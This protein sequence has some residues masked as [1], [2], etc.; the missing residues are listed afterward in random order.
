MV[1]LVIQFM[2]TPRSVHYAAILCILHYVKRTLFPG[3]H[4]S[5]RSSLNLHVYSDADW[6]GDPID[7]RSTIGYCFLPGDSLISWRSKKQFLVAHSNT[8]AEY[9]ALADTTFELL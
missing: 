3:L 9:R 5:F 8:E 2:T 1:H 7:H 6:A 4:F